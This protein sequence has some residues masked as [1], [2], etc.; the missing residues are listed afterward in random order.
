VV[1]DHRQREQALSNRFPGFA[2]RDELCDEVRHVGRRDRVDAPVAEQW[3]EHPHGTP[4][5]EPRAVGDV[6]AALLPTSRGSRSVGAAA[7]SACGLRSGTRRAAS[8][9][10]IQAA[11]VVASRLV[12][13]D[14]P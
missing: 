2:L 5:L 1:E 11:R 12:L 7:C 14:P 10:A 8:S 9:P 3:D 4:M 13:N 6:D